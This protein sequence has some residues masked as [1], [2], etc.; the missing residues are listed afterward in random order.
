[1]KRTVML[2]LSGDIAEVPASIDLEYGLCR[3]EFE[4]TNCASGYPHLMTTKSGKLSGFSRVV[5][6]IDGR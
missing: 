1:M 2:I 6:D 3:Y 4:V 5:F